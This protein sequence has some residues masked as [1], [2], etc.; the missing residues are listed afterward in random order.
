[1]KPQ[2]GI[3][4]HIR[5]DPGRVRDGRGR[6]RDGR[7]SIAIAAGI[8]LLLA[9]LAGAAHVHQWLAGPWLSKAAATS[10]DDGLCALCLFHF[11]SPSAASQ[12]LDLSA[13]FATHGLIAFARPAMVIQSPRSHFQV[14][15][16]P[17]SL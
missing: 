17:A 1:V 12:T 16:P 9:Q 14:R 4:G 10:I 5:G 3:Q 13:P 15:A 6:I 7:R 2:A 8:F 11:H